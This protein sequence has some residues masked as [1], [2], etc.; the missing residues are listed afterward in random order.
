MFACVITDNDIVYVC[1]CINIDNDVMNVFKPLL[2]YT[3][4][5]DTYAISVQKEQEQN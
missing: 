4:R 5:H 1:M 3:Y 2:A